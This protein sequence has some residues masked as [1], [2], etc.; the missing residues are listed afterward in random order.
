MEGEQLTVG[1]IGL[2]AMGYPIAGHLK[3]KTDSVKVWNRTQTKSCKHAT[4]Y[5]T[6]M[7]A[8]VLNLK[9]C[10][11]IFSC[12]P[13][14]ADV[15]YFC[16]S[17]RDRPAGLIWIDITSGVP[18][19]SVLI[20]S[21][22]KD[23]GHFY[24]DAPVSGGPK[25]AVEGTLTSMIGGEVK[26]VQKVLPWIKC[27]SKLA[28]HVGPCGS[29]HAV[30]VCFLYS[31]MQ[32]YKFLCFF[33]S[34]N[35]AMNATHLIIAAEGLCTLQKFGVCPADALSVINASSGRSLQTEVR[36]PMSVLPRTFDYGFKLGLMEK[37]PFFSFPFYI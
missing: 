31:Q 13:T 17:L 16:E 36:M 37:V 15:K 20:S 2:G 3:K 14:S 1:F 34:V 24:V 8:D 7:I 27:Y 4:Q 11:I 19:E 23:Y 12:L 6:D 28:M 9:S 25:G 35:N 30:K 22:L 5:S 32:F 18:H 10:D 33:Q 26:I 21:L 29:G